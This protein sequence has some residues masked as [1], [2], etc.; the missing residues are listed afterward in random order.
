MQYDCEIH[1][2]IPL[3]SLATWPGVFFFW[4]H[5]RLSLWMTTHHRTTPSVYLDLLEGRVDDD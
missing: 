2:T 1:Y 3:I 4:T 5:F